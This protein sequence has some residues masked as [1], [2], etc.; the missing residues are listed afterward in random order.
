MT[1][2]PAALPE[3]DV[4]RRLRTATAADHQQVEA[5]L[6]L[7]APD[8]DRAGLQR[9]MTVL[10]GF[11]A[12]AEDGL[13]AWAGRDP[14]AAAAV[15]WAARR[16]AHLYAADLRA[17]GGS[18]GRAPTLPAVE[19]TDD[20]LGRMYVLEGAT[21]GGRFI[22]RHLAGRPGLAGVRLRAFT[23]YGE[24][25]GAMWHAYRAAARRH[26]AAGGDAERLVAAACS[27]FAALAER[28]APTRTPLRTP[29]G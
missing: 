2:S 15:D 10:H 27:T 28:T 17:L 3:D 12:V 24:Q 16:R 22:D 19:C 25:T 9:A 6:G 18:P 13:D 20:A 7:M 14:A 8:L 5:D 29:A 4:L 1:S 23:P 26:V 21:L 11:W